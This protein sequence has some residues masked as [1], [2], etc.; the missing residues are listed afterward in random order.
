MP[1]LK[2]GDDMSEKPKT[3]EE[4]ALLRAELGCNVGRNVLNNKTEIPLGSTPTEFAL[5]LLIGAVGEI[6][7]YLQMK[8]EKQ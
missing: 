1:W 5:F 6:V 8:E 2:L 3:P 7:N 4:W